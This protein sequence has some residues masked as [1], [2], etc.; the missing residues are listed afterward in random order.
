MAGYV[1]C[2]K[3]G[4]IYYKDEV[5]KRVC[6]S[7]YLKMK[8]AAPR[9]SKPAGPDYRLLWEQADAE[10]FR[11]SMRVADLERQLANRPRSPL[12]AELRDVLPRLVQCCHPDRHGNSA[13]STVATQ[14][15]LDVK[16]RLQ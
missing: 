2:P 8:D 16:R 10:N 15:L 14:W 3:C 13:A 12:E 4:S 1:T 5:W 9:L 11:L 7:C 6:L